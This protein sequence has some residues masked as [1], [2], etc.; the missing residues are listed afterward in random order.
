MIKHKCNKE[1][2]MFQGEY[3]TPSELIIKINNA[4][5]NIAHECNVILLSIPSSYSVS[6]CKSFC[7][8]IKDCYG[9]KIVVGGRWVVDNNEKWIKENLI[10]VDEIIA[11]F[12]EQAVLQMFN[13]SSNIYDGSKKCF[14]WFDYSILFEYEKYQPCIEISRGCGSGCQFC[15]DSS[16]IR[17]KNKDIHLIYNELDEI[18]RLYNDYSLYLQ[19]PHFIFEKQWIDDLIPA[20][21][22]RKSLRNW[23]CTTRVET[24]DIKKLPR[25]RQSGLK[26]IAQRY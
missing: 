24:V 9:T 17:T 15:A 22:S 20:L 19:A 21:E 14:E 23:R 10:Y 3:C 5:I 4:G 12:G 11:G 8:T 13:A 18:D 25:L 6:W 7:R 2:I 16:N 1:I 26:V